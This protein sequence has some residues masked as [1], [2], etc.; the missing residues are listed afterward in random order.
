MTK[1]D[2]A[3]ARI[4]R[5][6]GFDAASRPVSTRGREGYGIAAPLLY[7]GEPCGEIADYGDGGAPR[8]DVWGPEGC[9]KAFE[10]CVEEARQ[11]FLAAEPP[12]EGVDDEQKKVREYIAKEQAE[13][14]LFEYLDFRYRTLREAKA[15]TVFIDRNATTDDFVGGQGVRQL[16][17]HAV[18]DETRR[19]VAQ[20]YPGWALAVDLVSET[21]AGAPVYKRVRGKKGAA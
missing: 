1:Q 15:K 2:L 4:F 9:R 13:R 8:V 20:K 18:S 3:S 10:A 17:K 12:A 14:S 21:E 5:L 19:Y 11:V 16:P 7:K 6:A